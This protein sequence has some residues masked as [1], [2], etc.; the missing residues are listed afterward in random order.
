MRLVPLICFIPWFWHNQSIIPS[1]K[2]W[3]VRE[4]Q[5][6]GPG[7]NSAQTQ[8]SKRFRSNEMHEPHPESWVQF[9]FKPGSQGSRIRPWPVYS[10]K[11]KGKKPEASQA[12]SISE[13]EFELV[14]GLFEKFTH[15]KMEYLHHICLTV[16]LNSYYIGAWNW[17]AISCI[18]RISRNFFNRFT[19]TNFCLF[20]CPLC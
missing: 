3:E 5:T 2:I 8:T 17:H 9:R 14:M 18:F 13:A 7:P 19:S 1:A 11:A 20:Y 12:L 4:V 10:T 16:D 15:E 6:S